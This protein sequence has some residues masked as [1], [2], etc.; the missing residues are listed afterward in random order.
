M[1]VFD[2]DIG[3]RAEY[4]TAMQESEDKL[5]YLDIDGADETPFPTA[6]TD[7]LSDDQKQLM[8]HGGDEQSDK[9]VVLFREV[10]GKQ[11]AILAPTKQNAKQVPLFDARQEQVDS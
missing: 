5:Q 10:G 7:D 3:A 11:K 4:G 1:M 8:E 9:L 2:K 6:R